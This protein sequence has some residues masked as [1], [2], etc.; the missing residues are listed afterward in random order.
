MFRNDLPLKKITKDENVLIKK[1]SD[2]R[3]YQFVHSRGYTRYALSQIFNQDP[4]SIPLNAKPSLP[5]KLPQRY[6]FISLS[7]CRD[8]LVIA[9]SM[10]R[11][12]IDIERADRKIL[13]IN[14]FK[15]LFAD[16]I[17]INNIE[18]LQKD[19]LRK[20]ILN[21]WLLKESLVKWENSSMYRGLKNWKLS[22]GNIFASNNKSG[23]RVKVQQMD[24][25]EWKIGLASNH[26][27]I[28]QP[29]QICF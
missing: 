22:R 25:N 21:F 18:N 27:R 24:F 1:M 13:D 10:E 16:E 28:S 11:I 12:G 26:F 5:P 2:N 20:N 3:A 19:S 6:G 29:L 14:L 23:E 8:M 7:H 17:K 9:W 15:K 4:L